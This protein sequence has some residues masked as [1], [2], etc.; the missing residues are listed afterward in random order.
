MSGLTSVQLWARTTSSIVSKV[1]A[2]ATEAI[3][4]EYQALGGNESVLG[5]PLTGP[6]PDAAG[7]YHREFL[8]G[9]IY[10]TDQTGAHEVHGAIRAKWLALGGTKGFLGYPITDETGT[11][12]GL[13]RY[14][15]FQGGSIYWTDSTGANE[16]HGAILGK[17][18]SLGWETGLLGYPITDETGTPDGLGRYNHFH[19]GSIYG[20]RRLVRTRYMAR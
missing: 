10:W 7:G 11:P 12:D 6:L 8:A 16:V 15:H 1:A 18:S 4:S 20:A 3:E 17:W 19:G 13:G 5:G 2:K 9:S 14:N